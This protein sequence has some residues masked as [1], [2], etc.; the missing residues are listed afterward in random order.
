MNDDSATK[1]L[2]LTASVKV[3]GCAAKLGAAELHS[4]LKGLAKPLCPELI[5]GIDNFEDAAVYKISDE[6]AV[7]ETIDFFPPLVDD[8]ILFGRIAATNALSDIYAMGAKPIFALNVLGFPTCDFPLEIARDILAGAAEQ[9]AKAGVVIAGGHTIQTSELFY[10]MAVTGLVNPNLMLVNSGATDGDK[11]VITKPIGTGIALQ[12]YRADLLDAQASGSLIANLTELSDKILDAL[13]GVPIRA[14]TDVTGFG[15]VGH[16]QQMSHASGL[17]CR[18]Y[19][20]Q[21]PFLPKVLE[22]AE[23]GFVPAAAYGNRDS[24][25]KFVTIDNTIELSVQDALFDPQTAGGL[26]LAIPPAHLDR[27]LEQLKK[28]AKSAACIGAFHQSNEPGRI[29]VLP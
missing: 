7:V 12:G 5:A 15:L 21:V 3:G 28:I 8:P 22:L 23:Q 6:V 19:A 9:A 10:G 29:E 27:S 14:A 26:L 20:S 16:L 18:L 11:I 24:F 25:A 1:P 4:I 17:S 2:S 13:K